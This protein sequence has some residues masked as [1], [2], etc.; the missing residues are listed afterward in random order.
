[1]AERCPMFSYLMQLISRFHSKPVQTVVLAGLVTI[2]AAV[3]LASLVN[4]LRRRNQDR[5]ETWAGLLVASIGNVLKVLVGLGLL[6]VMCMYLDFQS[7]EFARQRGGTSQRNYESVMTIWGRPHVQRELSC[8]LMYETVEYYD[9]DGM[10]IDADKL[11]ATS[12]P[13]GFRKQTIKHIVPG[14]PIISAEHTFDIAANYREKGG[15]F[16]PGFDVNGSFTYKFVSFADRDLDA[17]FTFP[18]PRRQ[19]LVD[20]IQVT[21]NGKPLKQK[22]LISETSLRW[23]MPV[24]SGVAHDLA[25]SYHSRGLNDL[26]FEPGAG[27]ELGKY[28]LTMICRDI[29]KDRIN[30]PVGCMTPTEPMTQTTIKNADGKDIPVTTLTWNL[31]KAV[32]RLG[33]GFILPKKTQPGYYVARVLA[34][35]PWGLTLLLAVVVAMFLATGDR[36]RG[37]PIAILAGGYMLYYL[38]MA[39]IGDYKPGLTGGMII[40]G[41]VLMALEAAFL[42]VWCHR[43]Q[44]ISALGLLGVFCLAYPLIRISDYE[45]LLLT[46]LYVALF[47]WIIALLIAFRS[48]RRTEPDES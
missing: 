34:G 27:R 2:I 6:V 35:A 15:A 7:D 39:H 21:L 13:V 47:A 16:Y 38:L 3:L 29:E 18:L 25:I 26:R 48:R 37:L 43:F 41:L 22:L 33:M 9:K 8:K 12:Q 14:N 5:P 30:Y 11:K 23:R 45:G 42:L 46:S 32:T 17:D 40:A 28:R 24:K 44:A 20:Q 1:M 10:E 36:L 4:W 19:G 31:D